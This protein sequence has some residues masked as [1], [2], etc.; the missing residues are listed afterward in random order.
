MGG[1][2]LTGI[3]YVFCFPK[4]NLGGWL[5]WAV[6]VPFLVGAPRLSLPQAL[7]WGTFAGGMAHLGVF[8]W[9]YPTCRWGGVGPGVSLLAWGSLS[10]VLA[11]YWGAFAGAVRRWSGDRWFHPFLWAATWVGLEFLRTHLFS[12]FPWLP[13][14]ASQWKVP[15]HW[16]L[17][18]WG[19]FYAVSFLVMLF[20]AALAV[21]VKRRGKTVV[22]S[23]I[24]LLGLTA[25]SV[26]IW[27]KTP[28]TPDVS[29]R[30]AVVQGN[31]DQYKKWDETYVRDILTTYGAL[32]REAAAR[33]PILVVW[34][35]TAVPG[36]LPNDAPLWRW[37]G[38]LARE[39]GTPLLAGAVSRQEGKDYNAAFLFSPS[40]EALGQYRK[41]HLVPF[42]EYVPFHR[43]F[44]GFTEV[45]NALGSFD[46]GPAPTVLPGPAPLG[47]GICYEGLFPGLMRQFPRS[48]A[49]VLINMTNDGWYRNTAGPEQHLASTVGRAVENGRWLI[50]AANTGIS[51]FVSP[52]GEVVSSGALLAAGVVEGPWVPLTGATVYGRI[53]DLFAVLCLAVALGGVGGPALLRIKKFVIPAVKK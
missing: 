9:I 27:R 21:L 51:A 46:P 17:A 52:R 38:D 53:G 26:W 30:A 3:L 34:P 35:E 25:L 15:K 32:T 4:W 49:Q 20:N 7:G 11:L 28:G 36:W 1:L 42:G 39:T 24:V 48:G 8:Y 6:F 10:A 12:G 22:P 41:Q 14:A 47:V 13:L 16:P 44:G 50:R 33:R 43:I 5:A 18:A 45:L 19:G 29:P 31:I 23:A 40:G 2:V 37:T